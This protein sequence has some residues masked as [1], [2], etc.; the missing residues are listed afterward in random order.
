LSVLVVRV[1]VPAV[2]EGRRESVCENRRVSSSLR[3]SS[4]DDDSH[5]HDSNIKDNVE[6]VTWPTTETQLAYWSSRR[7]SN[8][9]CAAIRVAAL[10]S[11]LIAGWQMIRP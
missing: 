3:V 4:L 5:E 7:R 8:F 6:P 2:G 11:F 9:R 10:E 1:V